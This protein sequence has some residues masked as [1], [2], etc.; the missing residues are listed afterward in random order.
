MRKAE[1]LNDL[2]FRAV[3]DGDIVRARELV[4]GGTRLQHTTLLE[5]WHEGFATAVD[6]ILFAESRRAFEA[7]AGPA[8]VERHRL[9]TAFAP[10]PR[11]AGGLL[12]GDRERDAVLLALPGLEGWTLEREAEKWVARDGERRIEVEFIGPFHSVAQTVDR[13]VFE[14][15]DVT[16]IV[17]FGA[18]VDDALRTSIADACAREVLR[19]AFWFDG[20]MVLPGSGLTLS[21]PMPLAYHHQIHH[22]YSWG[23]DCI[24]RDAV[25]Q[26]PDEP[27]LRASIGLAFVD[28]SLAQV[29]RYACAQSPSPLPGWAL[30]EHDERAYTTLGRDVPGGCI[31]LELNGF[32]PGWGDCLGALA[33]ACRDPMV[34]AVS[35]AVE[36]FLIGAVA[37]DTVTDR[38]IQWPVRDLDTWG[39]AL[40]RGRWQGCAP[41]DQQAWPRG[42]KVAHRWVPRDPDA[43]G[44]RQTSDAPGRQVWRR[45]LDGHALE[46]TL[47]WTCDGR[48][49][50]ERS[51]CAP[52]M[53][54]IDAAMPPT[55]PYSEA[56][57]LLRLA[58]LTVGLERNTVMPFLLDD[59]NFVSVLAAQ[60]DPMWQP[61]VEKAAALIAWRLRDW[62]AWSTLE[63]VIVDPASA[64]ERLAGALIGAAKFSR[65]LMD[66]GGLLTIA[67]AALRADP[68]TAAEVATHLEVGAYALRT[69]RDEPD[70]VRFWDQHGQGRALPNDARSRPNAL[71][72]RVGSGPITQEL[73][74]AVRAQDDLDVQLWLLHRCA[75]H[76]ALASFVPQLDPRDPKQWLALFVS[77][78]VLERDDDIDRLLI[79]HQ[80]PEAGWPLVHDFLHGH[81]PRLLEHL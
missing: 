81:E 3:R 73:I 15:R 47:T 40:M 61:L 78:R 36:A 21:A 37:Y 63:R 18:A 12:I 56:S 48:E 55:T 26:A 66:P 38:A 77:L 4:A 46:V 24:A 51:W 67:R 19:R 11:R 6:P 31:L 10:E 1:H 52:F 22:R 62:R 71:R 69:L 17:T 72:Q 41:Y 23:V 45:E 14:A 64:G 80:V 30:L 75:Q 58:M 20:E 35:A 76:D 59:T 8:Q 5:A 43:T 79:E 44:L 39:A 2:L 70:F 50:L 9:A 57:C 33:I 68:A 7:L 32:E 42:R 65:H 16:L 25:W 29:V 54:D 49:A 27:A 74:D 34:L 13:R 53:Q 28:E 60:G